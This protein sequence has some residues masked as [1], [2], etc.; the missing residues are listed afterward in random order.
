MLHGREKSRAGGIDQHVD[1]LGFEGA[2][3]ALD[4]AD[5]DPGDLI[6]EV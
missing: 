2:Q 6:V 3:H 5:A 1:L 4:I